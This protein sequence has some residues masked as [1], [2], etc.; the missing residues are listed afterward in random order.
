MTST[1]PNLSREVDMYIRIVCG[2]HYLFLSDGTP[3]ARLDLTWSGERGALEVEHLTAQQ[4]AWL[5]ADVA[6]EDRECAAQRKVRGRCTE[7]HDALYER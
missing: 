1:E 3:I 6:E 2:A 7:L 4:S 5:R